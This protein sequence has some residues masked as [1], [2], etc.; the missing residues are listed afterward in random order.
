MGL[1]TLKPLLP[2]LGHVP[3]QGGWGAE[4]RGNSSDRGYG[5]VWR[6]A[7]ERVMQRDCGLCQPC[8]RAGRATVAREVD[9][10]TPKAEGGTDADQNLQAICPDCHKAKTAEESRRAR[11]L[12]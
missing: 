3:R 8:A 12:A 11:G 6:K 5:A 7:R 1:K 4:H 9:H 2:V 10:I